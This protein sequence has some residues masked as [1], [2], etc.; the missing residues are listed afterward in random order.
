MIKR[1]NTFGLGGIVRWHAVDGDSAGC[2]FTG[3]SMNAFVVRQECTDLGLR[4]RGIVLCDLKIRPASG[5][6]RAAIGHEVD[7]ITQEFRSPAEI[8]AIPEVLRVREIMRAVGVKPKN[9]PPSIQKLLEFSWKRRSLMT[10]NNL[11][12]VYN[13]MSLRT[14]CSIGA[15]DLGTLELPVE[16]RLFQGT[17]MFRPLGADADREVNRGEFGYV[18]AKDRVVCRLDSMQADFS[19][20]TRST[21]NALLIIESTT[22]HSNDQLDQLVS[23]TLSAITLHCPQARVLSEP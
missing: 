3:L 20:I 9:H 23:E 17:E 1:S 5:E 15:H 21:T 2:L 22:E 6:L 8:R 13:L 7:R 11:V 18:D 4:A 19:K 12:D 10:I 16:L 14:R